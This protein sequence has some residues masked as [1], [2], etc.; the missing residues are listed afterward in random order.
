MRLRRHHRIR[1]ALVVILGLLFPQAAMA[2]YACAL[3]R[4]PPDPVVM[5]AD[6]A[7]MGMAPAS[8]SPVLCDRHCNPD[9]GIDS[10]IGSPSAGVVGSRWERAPHIAAVRGRIN[11]LGMPSVAYGIPPV[12]FMFQFGYVTGGQDCSLQSDR[13]RKPS[14]EVAALRQNLPPGYAT[15]G[16]LLYCSCPFQLLMR[17]T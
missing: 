3:V 4:M 2:A 5:A 1:I 7:E 12:S 17:L 16:G 9:P 11:Q 8:D 6:C 13:D 10:L 15:F 14:I